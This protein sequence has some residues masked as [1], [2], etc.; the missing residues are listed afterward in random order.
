[1]FVSDPNH[2]KK[3]LTGELLLLVKATANKKLT[4]MKMDMIQIGENFAYTVRQLPRLMEDQ[5]A[6]AG[7][8]TLEHHFNTHDYCGNWCRRKVQTGEANKERFYRS[9]TKDAVLYNKL[10]EIVEKYITVERLKEVS[11]GMDTNING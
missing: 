4:M 10:Q 1:M 3:L 7:L 6:L 2:C 8:A 9:K 5:Y 11:H